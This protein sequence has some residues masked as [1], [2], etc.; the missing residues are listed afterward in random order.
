MND[1]L[2][3][4]ISMDYTCNSMVTEATHPSWYRTWSL[5]LGFF[6][7]VLERIYMILERNQTVKMS[8]IT[9]NVTLQVAR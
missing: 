1:G 2:T 5:P 4:Y 6:C 3:L 7:C 8:T 9:T